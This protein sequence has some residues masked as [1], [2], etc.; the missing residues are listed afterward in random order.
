MD[1]WNRKKVREL[2]KK[3]QELKRKNGELVDENIS[4]KEKIANLNKQISGEHIQSPYCQRCKHGILLGT[5][6]YSGL[7][8]FA[9]SLDCMCKDFTESDLSL[10]TVTSK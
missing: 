9:C 3:V 1:F 2:E 7:P 10:W 8:S 4:L 5:S 6:Y